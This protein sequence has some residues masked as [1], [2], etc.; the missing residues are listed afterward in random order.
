MKW[1]EFQTWSSSPTNRLTL[2][3]RTVKTMRGT[4][5]VFPINSYEGCVGAHISRSGLSI[6]SVSLN[7][8]SSSDRSTVPPILLHPAIAALLKWPL[9]C[10]TLLLL[11]RLQLRSSF[12]GG[13]T[14]NDR[15]PSFLPPFPMLYSFLDLHD[16]ILLVDRIIF[17]FQ[18]VPKWAKN[19]YVAPPVQS[20]LTRRYI[21]VPKRVLLVLKRPTTT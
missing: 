6:E 4:T 12:T 1:L 11:Y 14:G 2:S 16:G 13:T 17:L 15:E 8:T 7:D 10:S 3:G 9:S 19:K 18:K 21:R 20:S 5:Y